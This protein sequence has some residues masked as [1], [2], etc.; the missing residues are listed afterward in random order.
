M[1]TGSRLVGLTAVLSS[2]STLALAQNDGD[3]IDLG[4]IYIQGEKL[5]RTSDDA[6]SSITLIEGE[7]VEAGANDDLDDLLNAQANVLADEGFQPPAMRGVDG[8]GGPGTA[9]TAGSQPRIPI[10]V[11]GV[12]L[13]SGDSSLSSK[14]TVWDLDTIEVARGPQA[15]S[16]GRNALGGAIRVFTKDPVYYR[17]G[18]LRLRYDSERD[19]GVDFMINTPLIEDQLA[20]RLTGE[21]TNGKSYIDNNPNPLP[22]GLNPNDENVARLRAKLLYEPIGVP[23]LSVLLLAER[24]RSEGPTEGIYNGNIEDLSV[25]NPTGFSQINNYEDLEHDVISLRTSYDF[26]DYV[27]AVARVSKSENDLK[28]LDTG[29]AFSLGESRFQ[30]ELTEAEAY[31]Q[32]QDVGVITTGVFGVVHSEETEIGSNKGAFLA[33]DLDGKIENTAIYGEVELDASDLS[34]GLAVIIGARYEK[35]RLT[36]SVVSGSGTSIGAAKIDDTAFLPKFGL[37]YDV[38]DDLTVGYT[39]SE[40]FRSGGLDVDLIAPF[41]MAGYSSQPFGSETIKSHEIYGKTTVANG[42]LDLRASAF[43]Y[44]W[45]NAQVPGAANY[46][47]SGAPAMGNVPEAQGYGA[48]FSATYRATERLTF[49]ANL[50][51]LRTEITEV[52]AGQSALLGLDLPRSP[53]TTASLGVTY[54]NGN[55]F[56]ASAQARFVAERQ[57]KLLQTVLDSY[58]VVDLAVG[59]ETEWHGTPVQIDAYVNNLFDER[60]QT[61]NSAPILGAGAPRALGASV[62]FT[63]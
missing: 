10:V 40:G 41:M 43:F 7:K 22:S 14:T 16:T 38:S 15:T 50:G 61:Y 20:F 4:T 8:M 46:P 17:E 52:G 26:N 57:T 56:T 49:D 3:V 29:E 31:V 30:K 19:A 34:P 60:Y 33:F 18:A 6:P 24:N 59:Y 23:G 9:L 36:R 47:V 39:Y 5:N 42:A 54:D 62:T 28:F 12:P 35:N 13:P 21:L 32:L 27:T 1:N 25:S 11:D 51:L 2:V 45:E 48:E 44:Q 63:F 37:R 53:E 55:G 58:T